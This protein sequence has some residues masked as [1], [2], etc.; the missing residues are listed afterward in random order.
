MI[1]TKRAHCHSRALYSLLQKGH[2][3]ALGGPEGVGGGG[4]PPP[5]PPK[6]IKK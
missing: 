6:K 4:Y 1:G 2:V 3:G 5:L